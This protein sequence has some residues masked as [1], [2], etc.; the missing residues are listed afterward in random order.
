MAT[1]KLKYYAEIQNYR[2]HLARVE[3]YR[4]GTVSYTALEIGNVCGLVL[5]I[6]GG[7]EDIITV[8]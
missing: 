8:Q 6:Q 1:Y 7:T 2:G 4:R 3:I 5:E